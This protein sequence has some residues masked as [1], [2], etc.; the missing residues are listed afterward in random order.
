MKRRAVL[1]TC[2]LGI[3]A[4]SAGVALATPSTAT[5]TRNNNVC[6]VFAEHENY[7]STQYI[8]VSTPNP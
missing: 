4:G 3:V 7:H 5:D 6:V 2:L 1:V 8:C